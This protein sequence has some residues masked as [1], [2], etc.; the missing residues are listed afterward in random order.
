MRIFA[1]AQFKLRKSSYYWS[2]VKYWLL[3]TMV[4]I[5]TVTHASACK[6]GF[7]AKYLPP[8]GCGY[9]C[10]EQQQILVDSLVLNIW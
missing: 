2:F 7:I 10:T 6:I 9:R 1:K 3:F 4:R 5:L 8:K